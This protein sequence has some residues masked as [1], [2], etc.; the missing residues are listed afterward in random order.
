MPN[1]TTFILEHATRDDVLGAA[2]IL[3]TSYQCTISAQELPNNE[4]VSV[5][6]AGERAR[7]AQTWLGN[8]FPNPHRAV[9]TPLAWSGDQITDDEDDSTEEEDEESEDDPEDES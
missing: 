4:G 9:F 6:L 7:D 3:Q 8:Q 5:T 1:H 2:Q